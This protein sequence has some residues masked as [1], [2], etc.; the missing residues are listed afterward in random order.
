MAAA[1]KTRRRGPPGHDSA[2][3]FV[4]CTRFSRRVSAPDDK[5]RQSPHPDIGSPSNPMKTLI[6]NSF[7]RLTFAISACRPLSTLDAELA[8]AN[9]EDSARAGIMTGAIDN[10][11]SSEERL[12]PQQ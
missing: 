2:M 3:S 9:F 11:N 10:A 5:F 4:F 7:I 8:R 1:G 12:W 6:E